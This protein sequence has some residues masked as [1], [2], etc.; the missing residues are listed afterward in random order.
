[1]PGVIDALHRLAEQDA[2]IKFVKGFLRLKQ[3]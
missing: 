2:K 3:G 1:V